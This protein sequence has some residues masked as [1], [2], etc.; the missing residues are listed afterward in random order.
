MMNKTNNL[1]EEILNQASYWVEGIN[2]ELYNAIL[3]FMEH[4][5]LNRT[6]MAKHLGISKGRMSQI[7][8]DGEI[9]FSIEKLIEIALKIDKYPDFKLVDKF[10]MN[11]IR[12]TSRINF[13][14]NKKGYDSFLEE[15][16]RAKVI[17]ISS[18][19]RTSSQTVYS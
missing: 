16:Q 2:N 12:S 5:A 10:I 6:Q 8:N 17:S 19:I 7:L 15:D 1:R 4:K 14:W 9:N 13:N 3:D 18:G 11:K